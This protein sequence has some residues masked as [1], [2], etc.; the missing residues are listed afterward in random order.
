MKLEEAKPTDIEEIV[1][2]LKKSLGD[3]L[4]ISK[5]TWEYKHINNPFGPSIV[6]LAKEDDKIIGVRAFMKWKLRKCDRELITYRAVD[7]ATHPDH[8]GK[9]IFKTLTLKAV[10]I[11]KERGDDFIFNFPNEKSRPGYLKMAWEKATNVR[12]ALKPA[13]NSFLKFKEIPVKY[14]VIHTSNENELEALCMVWN[15]RL[16]EKNDL[17]TPKTLRYL[18]WRYEENPLQE[19]AVH[20]APGV[21]LSGYVKR[22][23][24]LNEL[25]I[26]ECLTSEEKRDKS[27]VKKII[28]EWSSMY[29]AQVISFSPVQPIATFPVVKGNFGPIM[30]IRELNVTEAGRKEFFNFK[31]WSYSLGD[32]ELF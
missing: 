28:R 1:R 32:L 5:E 20:S 30:T 18:K 26:T 6:L 23:K 4:P 22:I 12:V 17:Y 8:R 2:V 9:G 7:T 16:K 14:K 25:R 24:G 15:E 13:W 3:E 29:G 11:A 31:N 10:E 27:E 19:Y 21:Y